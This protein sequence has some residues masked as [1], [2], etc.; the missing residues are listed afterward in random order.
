MKKILL[1]AVYFFACIVSVRSQTLIGVTFSGGVDSGGTI[2][3]FI[4]TVPNLAVTNSL[5]GVG[6]NF[7]IAHVI[8][9]SDGKL[10]GM[11]NYGPTDYNGAIFS[12]DISTS[13]YTD[14]KH[15][16][17]TNGARPTGN[18][19][20]AS[21]GKLYGM[22]SFGGSNDDGVIFSFDRTTST[23]TKLIDFDGT[24]GANPSGSLV[25]AS[26]GKLYGMTS[27]G[28]SNDLGVIFSFDPATST[29]TKL[30]DFTGTNGA[31][32]SGDLMQASDGKLYG[33]TY[34]GGVS[35]LG[36]IFSFDP[37]TSTYT[38]LKDFDGASG[39][40]PSS[41]LMQASGGKLYGMTSKGGFLFGSVSDYGVIFSFDPTTSTYAKLHDFD[42]S[43]G[44]NPSGDLMQ[45]SDGKL[46]GVT[47]N[48]GSYRGGPTS[49]GIIFS[50]DPGTSTFTKLKDFDGAY[51]ANP[52]GKLIQ[53][54]DGKLYGLALPWG[55]EEL[56]YKIIF[57]FDPATSEYTM[58]KAFP[59]NENG[60]NISASLMRAADGKLYGMTTNGGSGRAGIIF[61]YDPSHTIYTKLRDLDNLHGSHPYGSLIQASDGKLYGM[62]ALGGVDFYYFP[63]GE[64]YSNYGLVFSFDPATSTYTRVMDFNSFA[65]YSGG[66][67]YGSLIQATDGKLYGMTSNFGSGYR[68]AGTGGIF[69]IDPSLIAV[70]TATNADAHPDYSSFT[71]LKFFANYDPTGVYIVDDLNG[72]FPYGSLLQASNGKLYGMTSSGGDH[73]LGVIFSYDLL[74]A[75]YTKLYDFDSTNGSYPYASLIQARNGKLYGMTY[76]G[77]SH[78]AGIIFSYDIT[79]A[80]FE[81]L[82]DFDFTNGSHPYGNLMQASDGKIYGMTSSGGSNDLGV[83]F[84]FDLTTS[85]FT[86]LVD[87]DGSNG[88]NPYFGSAFIELAE[89]A[90]LP[91][92][93]INFTGRNV[94]NANNLS[95]KVADEVNLDHYELQR[96]F[97]G[98]SFTDISQI[99]AAGNMN[100]SYSDD[101]SGTTNTVYFYRLKM[102]D[103][104]G[105]FKFSNVIKITV[106]R[107]L[108]VVVNPNPFKDALIVTVRSQI[109]DEA[110]FVLTGMNGQQ[111]FR[112]NA[113]LSA[114]TNVIEIKENQKLPG[115]AYLLTITTSDRTQTIKVIKSD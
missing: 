7:S 105:S 112:K 69:S 115:G 29:Y 61:S 48:G 90:P 68:G 22:T 11:T 98:Q 52:Y 107:D 37:A 51:G 54:A 88:A 87:Y 5:L 76:G 4:P 75:T 28:G 99:K 16:D 25:Q 111:L 24:N 36:V 114:G 53:T 100:Y 71:S 10:Y 21:D 95:W 8:R 39:A 43:N 84:S 18:L 97:D 92:T 89:E 74:T 38:K 50:F 83:I 33:M 78:D 60:S 31:N 63:I 34:A 49:M 81:K 58:L 101:I 23:F 110:T 73:E 109:R 9:A 77:G 93:L 91:V 96:S 30:E 3:K 82:N 106:N 15:F 6:T 108:F 64:I 103:I 67:P 70:D 65:R 46:Y 102:V 20:Q 35:D 32:P 27:S 17:G 104:D 14:L 94:G 26:D 47:P 57:S 66:K 42:F 41:D 2:N 85:T 45:A 40:N 13:T 113:Q 55:G 80:S 59:A 44:A 1:S 56:G 72:A 19:V 62:T 12:F 86:K 79:S